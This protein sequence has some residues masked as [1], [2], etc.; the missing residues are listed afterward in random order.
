MNV[1]CDQP[2]RVST[3]KKAFRPPIHRYSYVRLTSQ[4]SAHFGCSELGESRMTVDSG[5][6]RRRGPK[7]AAVRPG[8]GNALVDVGVHRQ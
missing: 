3:L 1:T 6:G 5:R 8:Q 7:G 4:L 2:L